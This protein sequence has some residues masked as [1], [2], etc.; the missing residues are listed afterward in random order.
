M[1]C[2]EDRVFCAQTSGGASKCSRRPCVELNNQPTTYNRYLQMF[3]ERLW[4]QYASGKNLCAWN[5][6][7]FLTKLNTKTVAVQ[8]IIQTSIVSNWIVPQLNTLQAKVSDPGWFHFSPGLKR[9]VGWMSSEHSS[10]QSVQSYAG[11]T[12]QPL[13]RRT[14]DQDQYQQL[15]LSKNSSLNRG[16]GL[17]HKQFPIYHAAHENYFIHQG[18]HT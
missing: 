18:G 13:H 15:N 10:L 8:T 7:I 1:K 11:A 4:H 3:F 5:H 9:L 12:E 17:S 6:L 2:A 16:G 14:T